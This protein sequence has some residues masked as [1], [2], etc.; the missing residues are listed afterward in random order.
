MT[1]LCLRSADWIMGMRALE[2]AHRLYEGFPEATVSL[3]IVEGDLTQASWLRPPFRNVLE[4][5]TYSNAI[6]TPIDVYSKSMDRATSFSCIARFEPGSFD[7]EPSQL[8]GVVALCSEDSMFVAGNLLSDPSVEYSHMHIQH[9]VGN[10]GQTGMVL[11]VSPLQP[12]IRAPD[13]DAALVEHSIFDGQP[14]DHFKSTSLHLS[15]T[16]WKMPL[17]FKHTGEIDQEVFLLESVIS[18]QHDGKWVADIDVLGLEKEEGIEVLNFGSGCEC[19]IE[20]PP[21]GWDIVSIDSWEELLDP[22]LCLGVFRARK[23]WAARLAAVSVLVQQ[24]RGYS[25][26]ILGDGPICWSCIINY[27]TSNDREVPHFIIS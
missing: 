23:N 19:D 21:P 18:V 2:V 14:G 24:K 1:R 11:M 17:Y 22:P 4:S 15:F 6:N 20:G 10:V 7:I 25:A 12:R 26:A 9:L 8:T 13:H 27:Y 5:R 16:S 3:R